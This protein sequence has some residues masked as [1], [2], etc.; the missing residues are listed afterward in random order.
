MD[1]DEF[2][3]L[4][5]QFPM[6]FFPAFKLQVFKIQVSPSIFA[7]LYFHLRCLIFLQKYSCLKKPFYF[8]VT[9]LCVRHCTYLLGPDEKAD[10]GRW[11]MANENRQMGKAGKGSSFH[12][13]KL[14]GASA[15]RVIFRVHETVSSSWRRD[16]MFCWKSLLLWC[17]SILC[18]SHHRIARRF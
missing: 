17:L 11:P 16:T 13:R 15:A 6:V 5:V 10:F 8:L 3:T 9:N 18:T 2:V 4:N 7:L 14:F 12:L 1:F